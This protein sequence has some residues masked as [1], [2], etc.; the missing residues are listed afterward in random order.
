MLAE[1]FPGL[2]EEFRHDLACR[3][4]FCQLRRSQR[5]PK[6]DARRELIIPMKDQ[7]PDNL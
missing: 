7:L 6:G 4:A 5:F 2:S 3:I 1:K